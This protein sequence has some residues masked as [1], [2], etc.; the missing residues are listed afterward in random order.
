MAINFK[1]GEKPAS[2]TTLNSNTLYFFTNTKE[3]YLGSDKY[4]MDTT[5]IFSDITDIKTLLDDLLTNSDD[6]TLSDII[7]DIESS[8]TDIENW[9]G[10]YLDDN[11]LENVLNELKEEIVA[12]Q[13]TLAAAD[14][15]I[16]ISGTDK[17]KTIKVNISENENNIIKLSDSN[18]GLLLTAEDVL[19][20]LQDENDAVGKDYTVTI[21]ETTDS[22]NTYSKVYTIK[23]ETT[24][25][26]TTINIPKDL[27]LT[28]GTV[29]TNADTEHQGTW[30]KLILSN[31]DVLWIAANTLVDTYTA[32]N[33]G[34]T[35][36]TTVTDGTKL[37]MEVVEGAIDED[38][39]DAALKEKIDHG[40]L[41]YPGAVW[42]EMIESIGIT[43]NIKNEGTGIDKAFTTND[44]IA[45]EIIVTN[46]GNVVLS[47]VEITDSLGILTKQIINTFEPED[48]RTF[49]VNYLVTE[50]DLGKTDLVE[51]ITAKSATISNVGGAAPANIEEPRY[52]ASI[53]INTIGTPTGQDGAYTVGDE[54]TFE[55]TVTNTGNTT[56]KDLEVTA[57]LGT[58]QED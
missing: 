47:N 44:N 41:I 53:V 35:I 7:D 16:N 42:E 15:S 34:D 9:F 10:D 19:D 2:L 3:I 20:A 1:R 55:A 30:I 50:E 38:Y 26:N 13:F 6:K 17:A 52:D 28:S 40:E 25:L 18:D 37:S 5:T 31:D 4:S 48:E 33:T 57:S 21:T 8:I 56:L 45:Y 23:Q 27:V 29:V 12:T 58:I 51:T 32:N 54:I 49:N 11:S 39:I 36:I 43:V 46:S 24:N 14:A 22:T